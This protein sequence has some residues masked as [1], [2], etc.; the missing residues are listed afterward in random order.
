MSREFAARGREGP[1]YGF[2]RSSSARLRAPG[3]IAAGC[4]VTA[5]ALTGCQA[6][7]PAPSSEAIVARTIAA[8][9]EPIP[10]DQVMRTELKFEREQPELRTSGAATVWLDPSGRRERIAVDRTEVASSAETSTTSFALW[11]NGGLWAVKER[12]KPTRRAT[13]LPSPFDTRHNYYSFVS[14]KCQTCHATHYS[15]GTYKTLDTNLVEQVS[16]AD[17]VQLLALALQRGAKARPT[18][19][20]ERRRGGYLLTIPAS[21]ENPET[22]RVFVSAKTF[23]IVSWD[24]RSTDSTTTWHV[25]KRRVEKSEEPHERMFK[26]PSG[27]DPRSV[28]EILI[29]T[30]GALRATGK[31]GTALRRSSVW[32]RLSGETTTSEVRTTSWLSSDRARERAEQL[33]IETPSDGAAKRTTSVLYRSGKRLSEV[34]RV[35]GKRPVA[36]PGSATRDM[37]HSLLHSTI[38][39]RCQDCHSTHPTQGTY[40]QVGSALSEQVADQRPEEILARIIETSEVDVSAQ[41]EDVYTLR[42]QRTYGD[43]DLT[44][45]VRATDFA[46]VDVR[47]DELGSS[48]VWTWKDKVVRASILPSRFF[49]SPVPLVRPSEVSSPE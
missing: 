13:L 4:V 1:M 23:E 27:S 22:L 19:E 48:T 9:D 2:L 39:P 38:S 44:V 37:R 30:V 8:L 40:L 29:R 11:R 34:R 10:A 24:I 26:D 7:E 25:K 42:I 17:E 45:R 15:S 47:A 21:A 32:A 43:S 20:G 5:L 3:L 14:P 36:V 18:S 46:V 16:A 6:A 33:V 31:D 49:D 35:K 41:E 28:T 12:S